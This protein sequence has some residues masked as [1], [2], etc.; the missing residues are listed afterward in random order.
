MNDVHM[1]WQELNKVSTRAWRLR[2]STGLAIGWLVLALLGA[3]VLWWARGGNHAVP[4]IVLVTLIA[5]GLGLIPLLRTVTRRAIKPSVIAHHL[6]QRFPDLD[7]RLLAAVE[8]QPD[9]RTGLYGFL[10]QSVVHQTVEHARRHHWQQIISGHKLAAARGAQLVALAGLVLVCTLI[11]VD[12]NRHRARTSNWLMGGLADL[13]RFD[14]SVEPGDTSI[15]RGTSLLVLARF[16]GRLPGDV[17]FEYTD[18]SADSAIQR[19]QMS[20]SLNDPVFATRL[21]TV[22]DAISYRVRYGDTETRWFKVGV[23]DYPD[24]KQADAN[25]DFPDYTGMADKLVQD[26]RSISAVEG[27]RATL[28][29]QLNKPVT[30]ATLLPRAP[31]T[32]P[33]DASAAIE[34]AADPN[35][36]TKF[37]MTMDLQQSQTFKLRLVDGDGR[38]NKHE[39]ELAINVKPNRPPTLKPLWPGRDVDVSAL[40][41]LRVSARASDDFGVRR[42]GLT[43]SIAGQ[44]PLDV[45]L[46]DA[47]GANEPRDLVDVISFE[48]LAAQPDQLLSYFFWAEDV[49]PDGA[50]RR[51]SGD[52]YFA[53][54]R[55][56]EE[57]FRQGQQP[58]ESEQQQQD[59]QQQQQ[60]QQ[61]GQ[62]AEQLADLQKQI[63]AATWKVMRRETNA[64]PSDL[65]VPDVNLISES[66]T[67]A[68]TQAEAL[69]EQLTDERSRVHLTNVLKHM[70]NT[71]AELKL[72]ASTPQIAPLSRA[73]GA[74]QLA[75][76]EL[77]KLRARE[78]EV[79]RGNRSQRGQQQR[80][81][82]SASSR[83]QQQLDQLRLDNQERNNYETER[84]AG[85]QQGEEP[86]QRETRQ[87]LNRLRELAQ[88]QEDLN[89]QMRELESALQAAQEPQQREEIQ[90]QLARLRDQQQQQLRDTDELRDRMD[91]PENQQRMADSRQQLEQTRENVRRASESLEQGQVPEAAASGARAAEELNNLR[92]EFRR[93]AANQFSDAMQQMRDDARQLDRKQQELSHQLQDLDAPQQR[94]QLRDGGQREQI[95]QDLGQ[96]REQLN[97][98]VEQMR[99]TIDEAESSEPLLSRQLYDAVRDTTQ[100]K[101]DE[102][103]NVSRQLLERGFNNEARQAEAE[104][105]RGISRLREGVEQAANSVLGDETEALRRARNEL[106]RLAQEL[107]QEMQRN[108]RGGPTTRQAGRPGQARADASTRE[109]APGQADAAATQPGT[110]IARGDNQPGDAQ[111][112]NRQPGQRGQR[113]ERDPQ[114]QQDQQQADAQQPGQSGQRGQRGQGGEG[115]PQE[116]PDQ[117]QADAQQ[118]GQRGQRGQRGQG[119][120]GDPQEQPDQQQADAQQPGQRGQ[121][122]QR[123]QGE[124]RGEGDPQEQQ[125]QQ[126]ADAQQPG[127]RRQPGQ[128]GWRGGQGGEGDPQDDQPQQAR[129]GQLADGAQRGQRDRDGRL[130]DDRRGLSREGQRA[131]PGGP[132]R[133]RGPDE[134]NLGGDIT[135]YNADNSSGG[136]LTG[137]DFR[138]WSDRLRDVE[139][140]VSDPRLRAEASRIRQR[141]REVRVET[142]RHS[143]A[144]NW[145]IVQ[146]TIAR[147]LLDLRDAVNQELLRRGSREALVPLDREPVPPQYADQVRKYYE[148]LGSGSR[149]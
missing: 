44:E 129:D 60:G 141:A 30:Q 77:L 25:L 103:L 98:L 147:P 112:G 40:Q 72:A 31:A 118:P 124:Q 133:R 93:S 23:F 115:D 88:R 84:N 10:Q 135:R 114:E 37:S 80:N 146:D 59:Q 138:D 120:G 64:T 109:S 1:L 5:V 8:Q 48:S 39:T 43:Y 62:Q 106:D 99:Q 121:R 13:A 36:P 104:A 61:N 15:E 65:F 122:G 20:K 81:Q 47:V 95:T 125:D 28:V 78:F 123:G 18:N 49:G 22:R 63:I 19:A 3:V 75:Y 6:E 35:D 144:P 2:R 41:E 110:Q 131:T 100:Q 71:V 11:M 76:Q 143:L 127:Q 67:D 70:D 42:A 130:D 26:V 126:Q 96:Q 107:E 116:Q 68:R 66:Q 92:E 56:F 119:G 33:S 51:T 7:S 4:G 105:R 101:T 53:E 12:M 9:P 50:V 73:L 69:G 52:M 142:A 149:K 79:V 91:Q 139:E 17:Q 134:I 24:L 21:P 55:P 32:Q 117:Q 54:V 94:P 111:P 145:D 148:R 86:A 38:K 87:V 16:N 29:F 137:D 45:V 128:P 57:V 85:A 90:R 136:P 27:T 83:R 113:G 58:S 97:R 46:A 108:G 89:R 132:D 34:L 14:L 102:A 140:M 74:E 82:S